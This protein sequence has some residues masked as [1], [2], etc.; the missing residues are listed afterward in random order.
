[1]RRNFINDIFNN[2][3]EKVGFSIKIWAVPYVIFT[4]LIY[5]LTL[6]DKKRVQILPYLSA[7]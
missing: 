1:M 5:E 2:I 4:N 3:I 7:Y 6:F